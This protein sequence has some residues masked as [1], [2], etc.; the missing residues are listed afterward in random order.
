VQAQETPSFRPAF[1]KAVFMRANNMTNR[2]R[3]FMLEA[4]TVNPS[5]DIDKSVFVKKSLQNSTILK[6]VLSRFLDKDLMR[7]ISQ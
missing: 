4:P 3:G 2:D 6:I 1:V 7:E 5:Q